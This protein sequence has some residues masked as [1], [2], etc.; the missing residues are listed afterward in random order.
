MSTKAVLFDLVGT[1]IYVKDPVGYVYSN[2]AMSFGF[3]TDYKKLDYSFYEVIKTKNIPKDGE[4]EEKTWWREVVYETFKLSG[5]DL[6]EKFDDIF[7]YLFKEFTRKNAWG[8]YPEVIS[9]LEKLLTVVYCNKPLSIGL[10][11]NFD[12]RLEII[13]QE[14]GL[15]KY[16]HTLSYSG[17]VGFSKPDPQIFQYALNELN[18]IPEEA[19]YIGDSLESDYYPAMELNINAVF[20]DRDK[21]LLKQVP[22]DVKTISNLNQI[23]DLI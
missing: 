4:H 13:L 11:S 7:E 8:V 15:K 10:I 14:L 16:F 2:V 1:L 23:F 19:I 9:V 3:K 22:T 21:N 5:Y 6:K 20:I 17:K 12:S 18:I